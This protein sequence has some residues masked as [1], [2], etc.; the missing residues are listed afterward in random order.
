MS[1]APPLSR[2]RFL[3]NAGVTAAAGCAASA[4]LAAGTPAPTGRLASLDALRGF[5][6]FCIIGGT[7][8]VSSLVK[9]SGCPSLSWLPT[10]FVHVSWEGFRFIDLIFP[11]FLFMI[12]VSIPYAFAKRLARG[13]SLVKLYRHIIA[14]VLIL[15]TLGLMV[16]GNLLTYDISKL[17]IYSV[18]Q[19]LGF[20][21]FVASVIF[22]H[23]RLRWQIAITV[24]MLVGYWA[25]LAFVPGPGHVMGVVAPRCNVGDW[26]ND[27]I[28]GD[29][30]GRFRLGWILGILGHASTAMLGV[31]AA[32]I[33]RSPARSQRNKVLWL[34]GLGVC[35][36]AAGVF[37]G[38][39]VARW[40]PGVELFGVEWNDWPIWSPIIKNRWTSAFALYAGGWSYLLLALFYLVIDV[41]GFRRWAFPFTVIGMNSIFAYMANALGRGAFYSIATVLLGGLKPYV[42][43]WHGAILSTGAFAVLWLLLWY[44][45][46]NKTFIRV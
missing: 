41:W 27:W 15:F 8:I 32:H 44:M 39:W 40:F 6:M 30:Q 11:L 21:Y 26:L 13:D 35:C 46:R 2:R 28:L 45:Y 17:Q 25:L 31:F 29:W 1:S 42:G 5:D 43:V 37:W 9:A 36:L 19:M 24:L 34:V 23:F 22:L 3:Q 38:G 33:L 4:V 12:G 14:R 7:S 16:N 20:G 18:L 10:Q